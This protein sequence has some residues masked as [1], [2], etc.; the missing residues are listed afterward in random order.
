MFNKILTFFSY[1]KLFLIVTIAFALLIQNNVK[2]EY[3]PSSISNSFSSNGLK[4]GISEKTSHIIKLDEFAEIQNDI[5][6]N[7]LE[8]F[9]LFDV[10]LNKSEFFY[11]NSESQFLVFKEKS[12]I[13]RKQPLYLLF[14]ELKIHLV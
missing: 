7:E 9:E 4:T 2:L 14:C 1:R 5:E 12:R 6:E 8:S 10:C 11:L 13:F 3:L